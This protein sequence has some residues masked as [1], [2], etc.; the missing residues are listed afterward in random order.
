MGRSE[1]CQMERAT[2][3][4]HEEI[5]SQA[6]RLL[7]MN[8]L[9]EIDLGEHPQRVPCGRK[10]LKPDQTG[11]PFTGLCNVPETDGVYFHMAET[12]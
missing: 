5:N 1:R 12:D 4:Q 6:A 10:K 9:K 2:L 11:R 8:L 7:P 3:L